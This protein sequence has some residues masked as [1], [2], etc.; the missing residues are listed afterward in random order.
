MLLLKNDSVLAQPQWA[1]TAHLERCYKETVVEDTRE[2][3]K[4]RARQDSS[5]SADANYIVKR[6]KDSLKTSKRARNVGQW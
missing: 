2:R 5:H 6:S 4:T 3:V 1:D